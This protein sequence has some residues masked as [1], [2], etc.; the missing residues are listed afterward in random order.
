MQKIVMIDGEPH[1]IKEKLTDAE[2][3][4]ILA[5]RVAQIMKH[6]GVTIREKR[7]MSVPEA[8][9]YL[10][11]TVGAVEQL[12]KRGRLPVV[13]ID[14]KNQLDRRKLDALIAENEHYTT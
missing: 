2:F 13:K 9:G 11:R 14:S 7:L 6:E 1:C 12:I 4:E 10:G 3:V 8:A 5:Q